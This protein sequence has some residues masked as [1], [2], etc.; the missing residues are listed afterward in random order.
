MSRISRRVDACI[1]HSSSFLSSSSFFL[2]LGEFLPK[3][4]IGLRNNILVMPPCHLGDATYNTILLI[5][6]GD[7]PAVFSF[8]P[9]PTGAVKL[10]PSWGKIQGI[11]LPL[12]HLYYTIPV[13]T[14]PLPL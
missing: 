3:L 6:E 2:Y 1:S 7:T 5:N 9:D 8:P 4:T 12:P 11:Q 14:K 13:E 10:K